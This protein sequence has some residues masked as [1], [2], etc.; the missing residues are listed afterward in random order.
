[1]DTPEVSTRPIGPRKA[2]VILAGVVGGLTIGM[3]VL[4]LTV[5]PTPRQ[6]DRVLTRVPAEAVTL[7][8]K[9]ENEEAL[10]GNG[11]VSF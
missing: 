2:V 4:F 8:K 9:E 5:P 7:P 10:V 11:S 3:G 1:M 6:D